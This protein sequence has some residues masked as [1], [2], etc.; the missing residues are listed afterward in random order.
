MAGA[1]PGSA[2][3]LTTTRGAFD[4]DSRGTDRS[5]RTP[6][7]AVPHDTGDRRRWFAEHRPFVVA[8]ILAA[9]V[10]ML[11]SLAF[12]PA[13]M[14]SDGPR[15]LSFIDTYA[16][17]RDR[18]VG[19]TVLVLHPLSRVTED[20]VAVTSVQ[21][22]MGLATAVLL[23][24]LLRH[25]GV[26]RWLATLATLPVLFDAMQLV[27]EHAP[28]SDTPFVLLV[29]AGLVVLGWRRRPTPALALAAG[30]LLGL[31]VTVRQVGLPLVLAGVAFCLL[32]GHGWRAR[33]GIAAVFALGFVVPVGAYMTWYYDE[34]GVYALSEVDGK[35]AYMRTT[36]FVDCSELSVPEYQRVLCP[37]EPRGQRLDPSLYGWGV[38]PRTSLVNPPPGTSNSQALRQFARSAIGQQPE[39]YAGVVA[40][41]V[42]LNFDV[43]RTDRFGLDTAWKWRFGTYVDLEPDTW[44]GPA[45]DAH[46]GEQLTTHRPYADLV[47]AYQRVGYLP[48]PLL[49][50][51]LVLGLLGG[52]G[53]RRARHADARWVGLL[54]T[55][56]GLVLIVVPAVTAQFVWRYQ[57]PALVLLPGGAALAFTALRRGQAEV[58]TVAT[59]RID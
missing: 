7:V 14:T 59:P 46:G 57:L 5:L 23:Y 3:V 21:H 17:A 49:L 41:D 39:G 58:G 34:H 26:G 31:A 54:L 28:L 30:L 29:T 36:S 51:C 40:R 22:L 11:V 35:S 18:V 4:V 15:Y 20:L 19:Y 8:L 38:A 37:P 42:A 55:V 9:A 48:G 24:V 33:L 56:S 44:T 50:G 2:T 12:T 6:D 52:L 13:L 27:L 25:W 16:P 53:W 1:I 47:V 32:A 43:R 10:R 45:F